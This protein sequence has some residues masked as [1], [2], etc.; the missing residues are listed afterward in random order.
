MNYSM[1]ECLALFIL[2]DAQF[3]YWLV[4][5]SLHNS[6]QWRSIIGAL[7]FNHMQSP[8]INK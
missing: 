3:I 6:A 4:K 8:K 2:F 5:G 7:E 1:P